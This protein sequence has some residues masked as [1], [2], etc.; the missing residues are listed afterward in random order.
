LLAAKPQSIKK[1]KPS[2]TS[3]STPTGGATTK[4]PATASGGKR[5]RAEGTPEPPKK[6][7]SAFN[8]FVKNKRKEVEAELG[9]E[10]VDT[11]VLKE[12]LLKKWEDLEKA[13][14]TG[15]FISQA[16]DDR[17]RYEQEMADYEKLFSGKKK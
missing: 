15:K 12:V 7:K 2:T 11:T 3:T 14:K 1:P 9:G 13:G 10:N 6:A 8:Y 17:K 16:D 4:S 5:E